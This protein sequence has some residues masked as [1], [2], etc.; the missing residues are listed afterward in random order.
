MAAKNHEEAHH[1]YEGVVYSPA[2]PNKR[3]LA[4]HLVGYVKKTSQCVPRGFVL[5]P[6]RKI[7]SIAVSPMKIKQTGSSK[8]R[9]NKPVE[10]QQSQAKR[11]MFRYSIVINSPKCFSFVR[12]R[13]SVLGI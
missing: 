5:S 9:M 6:K 7:N 8:T 12:S 4:D 1:H 3:S 2:T 10:N 13:C 11:G